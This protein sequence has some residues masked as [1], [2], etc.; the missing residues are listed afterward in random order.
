MGSYRL[1][2]HT[3]DM[4]IEAQGE[5]LGELFAQAALALR[6]VIFGGSAGV[7]AQ[8]YDIEGR[9]EDEA[10][11]LVDFLAELLYLLEERDLFPASIEM[12]VLG[13]STARARIGAE[14]FDPARHGVERQVKAVTFH[15]LLVERRD[16]IWLARVYLDL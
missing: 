6:E 8:Y 5:S 1:L 9:G 4:G 16:G 15:R 12:P 3:A 10:E 7:A 14:P 2:E 11:L 13:G